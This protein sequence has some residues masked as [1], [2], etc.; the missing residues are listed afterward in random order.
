MLL[1]IALLWSA[2]VDLLPFYRH[3]A[4]LERKRV[5]EPNPY[6]FNLPSSHF[7]VFPVLSVRR[8]DAIRRV[9]TGTIDEARNG[10]SHHF[11]GRIRLEE[12]VQLVG[13]LLAR[14]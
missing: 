4:P 13:G 1:S 6:G 12:S 5:G 11:F 8:R 2:G 14:I 10:V 3:I 7:L 9:V